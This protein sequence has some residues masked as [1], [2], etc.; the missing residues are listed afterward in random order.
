[1]GLDIVEYIIEVEDAF[2][3]EIFEGLGID[4]VG[5]L[6]AFIVSEM[7]RR[8]QPILPNDA[9]QKLVAITAKH[10]KY[11][12]RRESRFGRDLGLN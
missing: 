5:Q 8:G 9:W 2:H 11:P 10:T 12:I 6:L 1:M 7:Q 3:I 4:T